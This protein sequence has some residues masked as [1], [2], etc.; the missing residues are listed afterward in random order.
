MA[1]AHRGVKLSD[2]HREAISAGMG[3]MWAKKRRAAKQARDDDMEHA[4][5]TEH[6]AMTHDDDRARR[7][8][9]ARNNARRRSATD[10]DRAR[11]QR[12][13]KRHLTTDRSRD[14]TPLDDLIVRCG[15]IV[16]AADIAGIS[17]QWLHTQQCR[18]AMTSARAAL[19]MIDYVAERDEY[20]S[21]DTSAPWH[22][23]RLADVMATD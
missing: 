6:D 19:A 15:G 4:D 10:D 16:R 21:G 2:A 22:R 18:G 23:G 7:R 9:T 11:R 14:S 3:R 13:A 1:A 8:D 5:D 20:A 17:R 12:A